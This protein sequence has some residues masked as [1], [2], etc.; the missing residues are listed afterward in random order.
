MREQGAKQQQTPENPIHG[1]APSELEQPLWA[2]ISFARRE[3]AD[4]TY[5]EAERI[6]AE[7]D[8]AGV[9]GLCIV[10]SEAASRVH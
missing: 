2:V 4:L 3:A 10:T 9:T 5:T 6:L 8:A 7:L 1:Q